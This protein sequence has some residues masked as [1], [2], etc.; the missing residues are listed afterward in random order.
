[1]LLSD[2]NLYYAAFMMEHP[3]WVKDNKCPKW[4]DTEWSVPFPKLIDS[5]NIIAF[6]YFIL[7][8]KNLDRTVETLKVAASL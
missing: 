8:K 5:C 7:F 4:S 6:P 1:M 3:W 2:L